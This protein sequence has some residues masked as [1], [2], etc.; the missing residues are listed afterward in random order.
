MP[1]LATVGTDSL[2]PY[3]YA[4]AYQRDPFFASNRLLLAGIGTNGAN[5]STFTDST[6]NNTVTRTGN[7]YQGSDSPFTLL[8]NLPY[9][10]LVSGGSAGFDGTGDYLSVPD[11]AA[12]EPGAGDFCIE[13]W[14][15]A[16]TI[17][18]TSTLLTKRATASGFGPYLIQRVGSSIQISLSSNGTSWDILSANT[19]G[20]AIGVNTWFRVALYRSGNNFY[21]AM[22]SSSTGSLIVNSTSALVNNTSAIYIGGD[23]NTNSF[24]GNIG[25]LR[26][27]NGSSVYTGTSSPLPT[28]PYTNEGA[29]TKLLLNFTNGNVY[30]STQYCNFQTAAGATISTAQ[31]KWGGSS[32]NF[33]QTSTGYMQSLDTQ[34]VALGAGNFTVD[35]WMYVPTRL[36]SYALD[37]NGSTNTADRIVIRLESNGTFTLR[38]A[39]LTQLIQTSASYPY[40][41]AAW[42]HIAMM[43]VSGDIG[44]YVNG[45]RAIAAYANTTAFNGV[46]NG[47]LAIGGTYSAGGTG[48]VGGFNIQD[49]RIT[50]GLARFNSSTTLGAQAFTPPTGPAPLVGP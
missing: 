39:S 16:T 45:V 20:A 1:V 25:S 41:A 24:F 7:V 43:R 49:F 30:D 23:S 38:G 9:N 35:F 3:G 46:Y 22:N 5:N 42:A 47:G 27:T 14:A 4:A 28:A 15:Y 36:L 19:V 6:G 2:R 13:F 50:P 17:T 32:I 33:T 12:L 37:I 48:G 11:S 29:N 18:G 31:E 21:A 44:I 34:N 10:A 8:P 26:I 40:P